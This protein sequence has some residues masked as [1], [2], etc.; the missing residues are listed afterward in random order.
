MSSSSSDQLLQQQ[1]NS[2]WSLSSKS[3]Q[4]LNPRA[5]FL[6]ASN[7]IQFKFDRHARTAARQKPAGQQSAARINHLLVLQLQ[8]QL[9]HRLQQLRRKQLLQLLQGPSSNFN[10]KLGQ[11]AGEQVLYI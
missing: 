1:Y 9:Q 10:F 4:H 7:A 11:A 8:Q 3:S 5:Q 2:C 6:T